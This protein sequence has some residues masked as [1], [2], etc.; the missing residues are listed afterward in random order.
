MPTVSPL[1]VLREATR[2]VP[3]VSSAFGVLGMAAAAR[4]RNLSV[5][6]P[7]GGS[8]QPALRMPAGRWWPAKLRWPPA[9]DMKDTPGTPDGVVQRIQLTSPGGR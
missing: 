9:G 3:T 8:S 2:K 5:S 6:I 7:G 4:N 1:S